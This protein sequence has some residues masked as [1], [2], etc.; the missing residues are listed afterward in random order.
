MLC[1]DLLLL[2]Q[3]LGG[4]ARCFC[5]F[6][7]FL[8]GAAGDLLAAG[9]ARGLVGGPGDVDGH[10]RLDLGMEADADL[11]HAQ[12]LDRPVEQDLA[13]LERKAACGDRLGDVARATE[14]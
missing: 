13:P 7:G 6:L 5:I 3:G 14:P 12:H 10:M 2:E 4:A 9:L 1:L 11:V 8:H